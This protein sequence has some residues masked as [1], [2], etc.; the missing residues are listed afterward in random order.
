M[1]IIGKTTQP[2]S[3]FFSPKEAQQ[4]IV[5]QLQNI[6]QKYCTVKM[7]EQKNEILG[8]SGLPLCT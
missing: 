6:N 1:L 8:T 3:N 5:R 7:L 4:N 2:I